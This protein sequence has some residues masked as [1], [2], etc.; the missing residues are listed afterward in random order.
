MKLAMVLVSWCNRLFEWK[1]ALAISEANLFHVG[2]EVVAANTK[3]PMRSQ[4]LSSQIS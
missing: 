3:T 2:G 4:C 1:Q